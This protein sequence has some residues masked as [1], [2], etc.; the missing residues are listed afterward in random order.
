MYVSSRG[1]LLWSG[2]LACLVGGTILTWSIFHLFRSWR[3]RR[4]NGPAAR[5]EPLP[6]GVRPTKSLRGEPLLERP[7]MRYYKEMLLIWYGAVGLLFV[8]AGVYFL[9]GASGVV[10]PIYSNTP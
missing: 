8:E 7:P 4:A 6:R 9:L 2:V 5:P 1:S 10:G 3:A